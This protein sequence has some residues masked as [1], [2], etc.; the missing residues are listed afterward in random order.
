MT[1]T[2]RGGILAFACLAQFMVVL[3]IAIVNVALP[4]IRDDLGIA[5]STVQWIVVAYGL[6]LGGF[7]LLGGRLAD[8]L[9]RRRVLLVGL[10]VFTAAS[11]LAGAVDTVGLL[12]AA[13]AVQGLGAALIPPAALATIAVTFGEGRERN[14]ALGLYG[15]VT[16]ISASAGVIASGLLTDTFGWRSVFLVNVPIGVL[17]IVMAAALLPRLERVE[18]GRRFDLAGA[19]AVTGSLVLLVYGLTRGADAG[20][21]S[22]GSVSCLAAAGLLLAA[23]VTIEKRAAAPLVPTAAARS[24]TLGAAS[25][26]AFF[27]FATLFAFIFLGSLLMQELFRYSPTRTGVAWLATT[28]VSFVAAGVTGSRL[29]HVVGVGRLLVAGQLLLGAAGLL[30]TR[31][32]DAGHY[33][34]DL[35]PALVLAGVGGGL[36]APA[37]QIGGLSGVLPEMVGVASG[38]LETVR[39]IGA[40][41]GVAAVSSVLVSSAGSRSDAFHSAYWVVVASGLV[42]ALAAAATYPRPAV[43]LVGSAEAP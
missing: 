10:T 34:P 19:L 9:G 24:L 29:V 30:L 26:A 1:T 2:R 21:T 11:L 42:G 7:L 3:D 33:A 16:G 14:R 32:P 12:I 31:V 15:A 25:T 8:L 38:L 20:W 5:P 36:A 40:V 28:L 35:L 27:A 6:P 23:F 41:V 4:S 37:A 39:E 22:A 17:L 13:R 43:A 18:T